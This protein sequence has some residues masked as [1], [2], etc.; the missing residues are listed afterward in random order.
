MTLK[1]ANIFLL[2]TAASS[3]SL[4]PCNPVTQTNN[5]QTLVAGFKYLNLG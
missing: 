3:P 2:N 1:S 5:P 4:P